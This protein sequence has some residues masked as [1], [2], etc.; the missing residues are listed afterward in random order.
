METIVNQYP[1]LWFKNQIIYSKTYT[2]IE[3]PALKRYTYQHNSL[4]YIR[5]IKMLPFLDSLSPEVNVDVV[6]YYQKGDWHAGNWEHHYCRIGKSDR[7]DD[8]LKTISDNWDD[9]GGWCAEYFI[10]DMKR[11]SDCI[12]RFDYDPYYKITGAYCS[13][14]GI[15]FLIHFCFYDLNG[16]CLH[17]ECAMGEYIRIS[18]LEGDS[19]ALKK[20]ERALHLTGGVLEWNPNSQR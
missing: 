5:Y 7:F 17:D 11:L 15:R 16:P 14:D 3:H 9:W 1:N 18:V 6:L 2:L 13:L 8:F 20:I 4:K 12:D 10:W 19:H